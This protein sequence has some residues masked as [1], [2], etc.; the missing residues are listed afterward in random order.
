MK[1]KTVYILRGVPG[2]GKTT[3]AKELI[4]NRL[5]TIC[6]ADDYFETDEG[7]KFDFSKLRQAHEECQRKF[8]LAVEDNF[9]EV[10][11][12]ANT[13]TSEKEWTFYKEKAEKFGHKVFFL[14]VENRHGG[15]N[16]HGVPEDKLGIMEQR[17]KDS[18]KLL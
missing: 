2:S 12:V 6:T 14:V 9:Y 18:I 15:K 4:N 17:V 10:I 8:S 7:Y 3:L 1:Q 11:V 13:N 5:G 16:E